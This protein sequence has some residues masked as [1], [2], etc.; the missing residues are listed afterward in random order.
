VVVAMIQGSLYNDG[1]NGSGQWP[2]DNRRGSQ[3]G[4]VIAM[5]SMGR[6]R[7]SY[8]ILRCDSATCSRATVIEPT[9][10]IGNVTLGSTHTVAMQW[11]G[12]QQQALFQLDDHEVVST[13]PVAAGYPVA[14][15]PNRPF[16]RIAVRAA[17][18]PVTAPFSGSIVADFDNIKAE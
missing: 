3:V 9:R 1:T 8:E 10:T 12:A 7:V 18:V 17:P 16:R 5:V 15:T 6:A 13:D 4:D 11:D 14:D 2:D